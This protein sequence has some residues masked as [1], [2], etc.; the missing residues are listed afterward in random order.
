MRIGC[1]VKSNAPYPVTTK[2]SFEV[3]GWEVAARRAMKDHR[4]KLREQKR[5]RKMGD[6]VV[7]T[8]WKEDT[9]NLEA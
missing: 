5:I 4:D 9:E 1:E 3:S 7:I 6:R 8:L 2:E